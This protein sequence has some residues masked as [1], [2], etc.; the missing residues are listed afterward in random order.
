MAK[1]CRP[2]YTAVRRTITAYPRPASIPPATPWT[3]R[4]VSRV[5]TVS[6]AAVTAAAIHGPERVDMLERVTGFE[7]VSTALQAGS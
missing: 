2:G 5:A 7:P 3:A 4:P 1:Q 6:N